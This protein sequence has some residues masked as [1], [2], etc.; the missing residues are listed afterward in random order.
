MMRTTPWLLKGRMPKSDGLEIYALADVAE[1]RHFVRTPGRPEF[2]N[3]QFKAE[4]HT[5]HVIHLQA[6]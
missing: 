1:E 2:S 5:R 3:Y 4:H 6:D